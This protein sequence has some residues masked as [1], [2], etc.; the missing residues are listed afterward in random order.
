MNT[1]LLNYSTTKKEDYDFEFEV[2]ESLLD[3]KLSGLGEKGSLNGKNGDLILKPLICNNKE[4]MKKYKDY[5][6][7]IVK[8]S[9]PV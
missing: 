8:T 4:N 2:K 5:E 9:K 3:I 7:E 6:V 1:T